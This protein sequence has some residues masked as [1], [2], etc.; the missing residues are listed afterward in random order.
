MKLVSEPEWVTVLESR[1]EYLV[2]IKHM[3]LKEA[4]I[5]A[6]IFDQRDS[7]YNTFGYMYLKV[8]SED[9]EE[10]NKLLNLDHE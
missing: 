5:P 10:A 3:K 2:R 6:I 4:E 8:R 9:V 7:S 1:D